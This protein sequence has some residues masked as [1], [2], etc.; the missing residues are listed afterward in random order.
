MTDIVERL[1]ATVNPSVYEYEYGRE[2]ERAEAAAEIERL[3]AALQEI[4][5]L[6]KRSPANPF[7][8]DWMDRVAIA[9]LITPDRK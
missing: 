1:R 5:D 6:C 3:R 9:A 8:A 4:T 2:G 7:L